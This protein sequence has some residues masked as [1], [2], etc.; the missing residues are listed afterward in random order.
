MQ[1]SGL[2]KG[3]GKAYGRRFK[4]GLIALALTAAIFCGIYGARAQDI[5]PLPVNPFPGLRALPLTPFPAPHF[6]CPT[7]LNSPPLTLEQLYGKVALIDFWEYTCINCIRTFPHLKRWNEL[8]GPL[9]L[10]VIGVHTP[11]FDFAKDPR[12]VASAVKR[13]GF[14]FPIAVDSDRLVWDDFHVNAWPSD[15]LI[16]KDGNVVFVHIGE[17]GYSVLERK[18]QELL[19]Q[20]NPALDF[21]QAKYAIPPEPSQSGGACLEPTPETYL[22]FERGDRLANEQG[23]AEAKAA[24]YQLPKEIAMDGFGLSGGWLASPENLQ[25]IGAGLTRPSSLVLKF[26]AQS[27]YLVAGT[28]D[29]VPRALYVTQDGKPVGMDARGVDVKSDKRAATYIS[30]GAKRMY[31]LVRNPAFGRHTLTLTAYDPIISLYSFTFGNNCET[32]FDRK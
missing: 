18:I 1:S 13:F 7:W 31:Y 9:G 21:K 20:A 27:V 26:R 12:R 14:T 4:S 17:G 2:Q 19:K 32:P 23:Y 11:E 25:T 29:G 3:G 22:G 10:V 15:D 28:G 8:Y 24:S 6:K 30:V 5:L 16:D